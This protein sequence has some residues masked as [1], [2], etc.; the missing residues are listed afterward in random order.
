MLPYSVQDPGKNTL[1]GFNVAVLAAKES[2]QFNVEQSVLIIAVVH[3]SVV[4]AVVAGEVACHFI[5][6][7]RHFI[8]HFT[9]V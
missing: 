3:F 4:V 6:E 1:R 9:V 5:Y 7:A 2:S 8:Y